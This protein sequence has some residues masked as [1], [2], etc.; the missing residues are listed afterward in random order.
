MNKESYSPDSRLPLAYP[1][2]ARLVS[3]T[4]GEIYYPSRYG[5]SSRA[6]LLQPSPHQLD[7]DKLK[8]SFPKHSG[9]FRSQSEARVSCTTLHLPLPVHTA[10]FEMPPPRN[11]VSYSRQRTPLLF[12]AFFG[13]GGLFIGLKWR[14]VMQRSEAANKAGTAG[15]N[16]SVAPGR[17]GGGV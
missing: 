14:A 8:L 10:S 11:I 9:L 2:P 1:Y 5:S 3:G 16:Y 7:I 17:S 4:C 15:I 6:I 12:L 13:V